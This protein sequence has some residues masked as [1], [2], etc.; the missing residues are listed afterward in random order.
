[1]EKIEKKEKATTTLSRN[2][3]A[4][5]L[6]FV[7]VVITFVIL[8][9]VSNQLVN[10]NGL[11]QVYYSKKPISVNT[12]ITD[13]NVDDYFRSQ[14]E[15]SSKVID[16]AITNKTALEKKYV[17]TAMLKN[18]QVSSKMLDLTADK[19]KGIKNLIE[20]SINFSDIA[21]DV[22]GTLRPGDIVNLFLTETTSNS[23]ITKPELKNVE[24]SKAITTDGQ[25]ISRDDATKAASK[26]TLYLSAGDGLKLDNALALGKVKVQKVLDNT[27]SLP[28]IIQ[29]VKTQ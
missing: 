27:T 26:L 24:I 11:T 9:V 21:D 13:K 22:G 17:T 28:V 23:I 12:E 10:P 29:S 3:G 20:Q 2:A 5:F 7:F 4:A 25:L 6:G 18:E 1:M 14:K 8:I 19:T 15:D 16:G